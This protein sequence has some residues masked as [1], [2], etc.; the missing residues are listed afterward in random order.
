MIQIIGLLAVQPRLALFAFPALDP[1][2]VRS[3]LGYRI[4][5]ESVFPNMEECCL[6]NPK[7]A[8]RVLCF[9]FI[10]EMDVIICP[11]VWKGMFGISHR[12]SKHSTMANN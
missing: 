7:V 12:N 10:V 3:L 11:Y 6:Q 9:P 2:K 4:L 8:W 1:F 5:P